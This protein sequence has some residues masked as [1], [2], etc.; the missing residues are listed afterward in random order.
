MTTARTCDICRASNDCRIHGHHVLE[1]LG[2][3]DPASFVCWLRGG[4]D[5]PP[6]G[7]LRAVGVLRRLIVPERPQVGVDRLLLSAQVIVDLRVPLLRQVPAGHPPLQ[8]GHEI[9]LR[10]PELPVVLLQH[11]LPLVRHPV[12]SCADI[13]E[14]LQDTGRHVELGKNFG[15]WVGL[16]LSRN[17]VRHLLVN[18]VAVLAQSLGREPLD[19]DGLQV[20]ELAAVGLGR[21]LDAWPCTVSDSRLHDD[22]RGFR[23]LRL[24]IPHRLL[25][26][27]G[28]AG[29]TAWDVQHVPAVGRE[30]HPDIL[31]EGQVSRPIDGDFVVVIEHDELVQL[32]VAGKRSGFR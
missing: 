5:L 14:L 25:V 26:D 9:R 29:V 10:G 28:V 3:V 8:V 19:A 24:R 2:N 7:V 32:E 20:G 12:P 30:P 31:A 4:L 27:V 21:A 22:N 15:V 23:G 16:Q 17:Q 11:L 6:L 18:G 13:P 1:H